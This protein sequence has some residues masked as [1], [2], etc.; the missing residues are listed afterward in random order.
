MILGLD[1]D[2]TLLTEQE[3]VSNANKIA[4]Q[5]AMANGIQPTIVTG[6][7]WHHRVNTLTHEL[8]IQVPVATLNGGVILSPE[9]TVLRSFPISKDDVGW[10][11]TQAEQL[12][13]NYYVCTLDRII[14][15]AEIKQSSSR[16][17]VINATFDAETPGQMLAFREQ[18]ERVNRFNLTWPDDHH[19]VVNAKGIHK[20]TALEFISQGYGLTS[21]HVAAMGDG[22]NDFE[23]LAWATYSFAM[24]NASTALKAIA[25]ETTLDFDDDGVANAIYQLVHLLATGNL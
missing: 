20:A 23:M 5:L 6:R 15:A 8:G 9:G 13:L 16:E 19:V 4:L 1:L 14:H 24:G 25:R 22:I 2:G 7:M 12:G 3:T 10:L 17:T 18:L 21:D 11:C